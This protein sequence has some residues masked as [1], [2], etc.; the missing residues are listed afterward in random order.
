MFI[1]IERIEAEQTGHSTVKIERGECMLLIPSI[2][3]IDNQEIPDVLADAK[4]RIEV[5]TAGTY[6]YTPHTIEEIIER[7]NQNMPVI[8]NPRVVGK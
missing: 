3:S 8:A 4:T 6:Y 7:M 2:V 1:I 5:G